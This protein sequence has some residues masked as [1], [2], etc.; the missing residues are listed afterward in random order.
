MLDIPGR[1]TGYAYSLPDELLVADCNFLPQV[2]V[3]CSFSLNRARKRIQWANS[4]RLIPGTL[5]CLSCDNFKEEKNMRLATVLAR[6]VTALNLSPPEVDLLFA[7]DQI[8]IDAHTS[9]LMIESRGSYFEGN[10]LQF[11][12]TSELGA[13]TCIAYKHTLK[14]LQRM[15]ASK[16]VLKDV[17]PA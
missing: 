2:G 9:W 16:L 8:E 10:Y 4:K 5:V 12:N 6:P 1:P 13:N 14:A 17:S 15:K 3:K 11:H 7:D